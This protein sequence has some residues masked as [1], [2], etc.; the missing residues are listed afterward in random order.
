MRRRAGRR[1]RG[2]REG[3][4]DPAERRRRRQ[5][6]RAH[7]RA[8]QRI[9]FLTHVGSFVAV[10]MVLLVAT[11]SLRIVTLV[12]LAWGVG[13]FIHYFWAIA[14]PR[15]RDRWVE[16]EVGERSARDVAS[17]RRAVETRSLR[18]VEDLSA[19]IA[20]EIRNPI[21]AAKSLVQQMGEDPASRENL[22]YAGLALSELDRVE[23]SISHLLRYA[24]DE[25]PRLERLDLRRVAEAATAGLRDRAERAGV[26]LA[27]DFDQ[28]GGI[29]GDAEKLRRVIENLV[30][31]AIDAVIEGG[32]AGPRVEVL[33]GRSLAGDEVWIRIVD[34]G[35]GIPPAERPRIWSPFYT[36]K[37]EGTGLGLAL[38]RKTVEAH[39]GSIELA[40]EHRAGSEFVIT[41]PAD[42]AATAEGGA[43][44]EGAYDGR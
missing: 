25:E 13:V 10:L 43:Q 17:Q 41:F 4:L 38:S 7:R 3:D 9:A 31:N 8:N 18:R 35:P 24:R 37:E 33:G 23:R 39:G 42:P 36:T 19:S 5:L 2:P 11:R 14:A 30:A 16:Q 6:R 44:E 21:T 27:F 34:N 40:A 20:H 12:G 1:G 28:P 32:G 22:E 29:R 15:L 26:E